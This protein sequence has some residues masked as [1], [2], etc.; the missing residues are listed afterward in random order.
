MTRWLV[1]GLLTLATLGVLATCQAEEKKR[2]G[3]FTDAQIRS[4]AAYV[5]S[6]SHK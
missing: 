1:G 4:I 6:I 3:T 2:T 5:Y